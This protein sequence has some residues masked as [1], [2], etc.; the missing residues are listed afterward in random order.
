M[1]SEDSSLADLGD[2]LTDDDIPEY[3]LR[4]MSNAEERR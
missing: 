1:T 3:Q 4:A 2:Y